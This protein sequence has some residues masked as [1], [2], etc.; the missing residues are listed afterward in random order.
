[1]QQ[2]NRIVIG[3]TE[4][5]YSFDLREYL[6]LL[7]LVQMISRFRKFKVLILVVHLIYFAEFQLGWQF[8]K[9]RFGLIG[10]IRSL[11]AESLAKVIVELNL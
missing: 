5:A 2:L 4:F 11:T 9:G 7:L 8:I 10:T 1:L 6:V 3:L